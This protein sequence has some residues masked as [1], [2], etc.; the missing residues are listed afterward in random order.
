MTSPV[1]EVRSFSVSI[2]ASTALAS[3]LVTDITMPAREVAWV[4]WRVP[5]G[6]S[7]LMGWRL[8]MSNGNP[9]IPV[10]GG[11]IIADND[12][13]TWNVYDQPDSG[14]WEVTGYNTDI[15][16]HTVYLDFGL[17]PVYQPASI[18]QQI[19]SSQLSG[20]T[21]AA[22]APV[23]TYSVAGVTVALVSVPAISVPAPITA[24][25]P[26]FVSIP[27]VSIPPPAP[28]AANPASLAGLTLSQAAAILSAAGIGNT[29][30]VQGQASYVPSAA[31]VVPYLGNTVI[32]VVLDTANHANIT[33]SAT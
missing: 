24:I 26:V 1:I 16:P 21:S 32:S 10:G 14:A 25:Q 27:P 18:T 17:I 29:V 9:V 11:W 2:P 5:S 31:A 22:V 6:P 15:Y 23:T 19:P 13:A 3:P 30:Y 4:K 33:V 20:T 12:T 7:G 8:T 28:S